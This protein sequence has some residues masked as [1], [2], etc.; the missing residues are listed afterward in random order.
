MPYYDALR[1]DALRQLH[2]EDRL[3]HEVGAGAKHLALPARDGLLQRACRLPLAREIAQ[4]RT[5]H[6]DAMQRAGYLVVTVWP[7]R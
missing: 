7:R 1:Y 2:Y 4:L 5:A 6:R 3:H